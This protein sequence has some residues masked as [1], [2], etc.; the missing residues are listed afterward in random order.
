M[1]RWF[2]STTFVLCVH[3]FPHGEVSVKVGI[4]EFGLYQPAWLHLKWDTFTSIECDPIWQVML[5][6]RFLITSYTPPLSF[7]F[8][9]VK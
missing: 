5:C 8:L 3:A 4:M 1:S 9:H 2:V 6:D 7:T